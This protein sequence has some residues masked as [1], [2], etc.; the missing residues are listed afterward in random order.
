MPVW[1]QHHHDLS[2]QRRRPLRRHRRGPRSLISICTAVV[3]MFS[4]IAAPA[5]ADPDG[6]LNANSLDLGSYSEDFTVG[7]FT[8]RATDT[9]EVTVSEHDRSSS[10]GLEFTQR[11]QLGGAGSA[12]GRSLQFDAEAGSSVTVFAQSG[13]GSEDRA[14]GLFDSNWAQ[15]ATVPAYRGDS[16]TVLPAQTFTIP[17]DGTY[18]IASP[19]SGV[20]VY[21][22]ELSES[23]DSGERTPWDQVAAPTVTDAA[24]SEADPGQIQVSYN[25]IIGPDGA[26]VI[27]AYL[28][29]S[30]GQTVDEQI[31]VAP[32]SQGVI[33]LTPDATGTYNVVLQLERHSEDSV[34]SSEP[35]TFES[36]VLPLAAPE[37]T[38]T[39][40][41][42]FSG[43]EG[44]VTLQWSAVS[45]AET[46]SIELSPE[47][48]EDFTVVA[49]DLEDTEADLTGL[50]VGDT[51]EVRVT[52]HR[53]QGDQAS[54]STSDL[55]AFTVSGEVQ[56]W[57]IAHAGVGS[58]GDVTPADDGSV[59]F[60]LRGN[61][62]K[63]ADSED[64]F[65]YYYTEIDPQAENFT[66]S[67]RFR[68]DDAAGKDNQ[69]GFGVIAIDDFVPND[70]AAR[71]FNSAGAMVAKYEEGINGETGTRY[72][73]PGG[74]FVHGYTGPTTQASSDRDRFD[75]RA[76]DWDHKSDY[77]VGSNTNPPKFEAGETYELSLR[78]SNTGF[79]SM[80]HRD[81]E[82]DEVIFYE[83]EH[84]LVQNED[85]LYVGVAVARDIAVTVSDIE[86]T[87]V[88]PGQDDAAQAPPTRYVSPTLSAD[89][90]STT[91]HTELDVPLLSNVHGEAVILNADGDPVTDPLDLTPGE[92]QNLP[93]SDLQ[94]GA[95]DF[96]AQLT[97]ATEQPQLAEN[98]ELDSYDPISRELSFTVNSFGEPGESVWV[99]PDGDQDGDGTEENPLDVHTA[100]AYAQPGQQIVLQ[101]G[102]YALE[103]A[104]RI[105]RGNSGTE[106]S[107]I[108]LMSE[109]GSRVTFDLSESSG[110]GIIL[111]GDWWHLHNLELTDSDAYQKPLLVQG[112]HNV[113]ERIESH[114][115]QDTGLQISGHASEPPEMWPSYNTVVSSVSH[116]NADPQTNDADG[117]AAKLTVG[118]GNVFRWTLSYHNVDDGYD[119]YAKSTEGPI[120]AV[121]IDE[122]VAFNNGWLESDENVER[123][124]DGQ[125]FKL[126]GESMPGAHLLRNSISY[127]NLGT[128]ITSN[129]GPDVRLQYVT[130]AL[131]HQA[132]PDRTGGNISLR[133]NAPQTDYRAEGVISWSA[134]GSDTVQLREQDDS[135]LHDP[136]NYFDGRLSELAQQAAAGSGVSTLSSEPDNGGSPER[137]AEV[138]EEW[139]ETTDTSNVRPEIA[140]DGSVDMNGL[141]E[142]TDLAPSDTGARMSANP[143][144]TVIDL[145]P[146]VS[147]GQD[148]SPGGTGD[149][150][151]DPDEAAETPG[152]DDQGTAE[153]GTSDEGTTD[154]GT[155]DD[156]TTAEDPADDSTADS[157]VGEDQAGADPAAQAEGSS[158][159]G[160]SGG[161]AMTGV[162]VLATVA[163][164]LLLL[165]VGAL[166]VSRAARRSPAP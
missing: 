63:I 92:Q 148:S 141:F 12:E 75:S 80:W 56:R 79:H 36:F 95:N 100:V 74:R 37:I 103:E 127:G 45:E 46:Y 114:H 77:T 30:D 53:G 19:R 117:F 156:G 125:G 64:G 104:V 162:S 150:S 32:G 133:T 107:P 85:R 102:T 44:T 139:F 143:N 142:L 129:S 157:A 144:P 23:E 160:Q 155:S 101:D 69:S 109:P 137:P 138:T 112:H 135:L 146:T 4:A 97:P 70:P 25:G 153:E 22:A 154:Q 51:Y 149:E 71:Y 108:V 18:W 47:G 67:A 41:T 40:T 111:R 54:S 134:S 126:G 26:D 140:E 121:L 3:L 6:A 84:L 122:S 15:L 59:E 65:W 49:E 163:A 158:A 106:N 98:T 58:G 88:N 50:S 147:G 73:T 38:S 81:G 66:L 119:L 78:R 57:S 8:V 55:S 52:A 151:D 60:D 43:N 86:L 83:P 10:T 99:A 161:L 9:A 16:G 131:N 105:E 34:I 2:E 166:L 93:L 31:A 120:G 113:V 165:I 13:G 96:T 110:G 5:T 61:N 159:A 90:T 87:T 128:G 39:L 48:E 82:V 115:N 21:Y 42:S 152:A 124:S 1:A 145:M 89:V 27:R 33:A 24:V 72:G 11:L 28:Q 94:P 68:V 62:S 132:R 123:T 17:E 20:N 35:F 29:D 136:T 164:V 130:A 76:F 118:E 14:L 91:P 116:N 7:D